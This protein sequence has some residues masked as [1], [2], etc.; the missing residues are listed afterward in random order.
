MA[1]ARRHRHRRS[2][3]PLGAAVVRLAA[4]PPLRNTAR[5]ALAFSAAALLLKLLVLLH[6]DMPIGDALFQAH[7]FQEVLAG[8][9]YFT[10]IA[11]GQL[12]VPLRAG[13]L[14]RRRRRSPAWCARG[15]ADMTLLRDRAAPPMRSPALL[16]YGMIVRAR[17]DR[18][19]GAC[20]VALYHLIP[21]DFGVARGRQ[22]D[23]RVRAV[24][25]GASRSR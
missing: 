3:S 22:P 13:S 11:P 20:A 6:P 12:P 8:H 7:R 4:R 25:V 17:G 23:E 21:L 14:R 9:L 5:F 15:T 16:L 24:A 2:R 19:A 10:S 18:L 1:R